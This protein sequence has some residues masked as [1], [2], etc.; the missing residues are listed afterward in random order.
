MAFGQRRSLVLSML[1]LADQDDRP[2]SFG[3]EVSVAL[4]PAPPRQ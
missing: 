4:A 1:L 2:A 3:A